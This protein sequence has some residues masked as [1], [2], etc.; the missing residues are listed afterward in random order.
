MIAVAGRRAAG[1]VYLLMPVLL[2]WLCVAVF[3]QK[4]VHSVTVTVETGAAGNELRVHADV[5]LRGVVV[6]QVRSIAADG[7]GARLT[8]AIQP[9]KIDRIPADVTAQMLPTT[10]FGER[11]VALVPAGTSAVPLAAGSVIPQDRSADAIELQQVLDNVLPLLTAVQP[12]KL[13]ATLSAVATALDGRGTEIGTTL[14]GLDTYLK[15]LNPELPALNADI[16]QLVQV[17]RDYA[18]SAPDLLQAL[19]DF[20]TTSRTIAE[21]QVPLQLA[22]GTTTGTAQD[23]TTFLR[24]NEDNVIR[25]SVTGKPTLR[26]LAR[27]APSFPCT[28]STL[29]GLVPAMD[30]ALGKGTAEHGLHVHVTAVPSRG[31]YVPGKDT[32]TYNAS[33]GPACYATPYRGVPNSAPESALV[34][35]LLAPAA[36]TDAASLPDWSSLLAGPLFRGTEVTVQ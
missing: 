23:L 32:P 28:L 25:L 12:Q 6:G 11:Y 33:G 30:K 24:Q 16:H 1:V 9:G 3:Q 10:L 20:T 7:A 21:Q 29:A 2:A 15:K 31:K 35:E 4:F 36:H 13:S 27:Y 22:Y 34:N 8:L 26:L 18:R 19:S 17:S 5:K 14:I